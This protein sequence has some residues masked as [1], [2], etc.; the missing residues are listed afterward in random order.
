MHPTFISI[1]QRIIMVIQGDRVAH[2]TP[3]KDWHP[4]LKI[5][6]KVKNDRGGIIVPKSRGKRRNEWRG[7]L[8]AVEY[9]VQKSVAFSATQILC[10]RFCQGPQ[11]LPFSTF[12]PLRCH[13]MLVIDYFAEIM[14]FQGFTQVKI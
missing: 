11:P 10:T 9:R 4:W 14:T 13:C 2:P 5:I 8:E 6:L 7:P 1:Q 12:N 3:L